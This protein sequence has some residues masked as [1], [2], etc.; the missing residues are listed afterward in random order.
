MS[1]NWND[2]RFVGSGYAQS[3]KLHGSPLL[4]AGP[5]LA[6]TGITAGPFTGDSFPGEVLVRVVSREDDFLELT[7]RSG[8]RRVQLDQRAVPLLCRQLLDYADLLLDRLVERGEDLPPDGDVRSQMLP[9]VDALAEEG[10]T[11]SAGLYGGGKLATADTG[12][13]LFW[14][15]A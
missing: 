13:V 14:R 3:M 9:T 15:P 11:L 1:T 5:R 7:W 4:S 12:P 10:V 8:Q 6:R 2:S